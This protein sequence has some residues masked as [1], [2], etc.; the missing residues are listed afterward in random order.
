MLKKVCVVT[1]ISSKMLNMDM[2]WYQT[3][4]EV[5]ISLKMNG[6]DVKTVTG[7]FDR[8]QCIVMA[9]SNSVL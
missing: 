3:D 9:K 5:T 7:K 1:P 6:V 4:H 8:K 2:Q